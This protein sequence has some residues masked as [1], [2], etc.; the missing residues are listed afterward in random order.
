MKALPLDSRSR[1]GRVPSGGRAC[2]VT[3][4]LHVIARLL[5]SVTLALRGRK[6]EPARAAD[7]RLPPSGGGGSSSAGGL[8]S[9]DKLISVAATAA[10]HGRPDRVHAAKPGQIR[11]GAS[12]GARPRQP[13]TER[14][15]KGLVP[16]TCRLLHRRVGAGDDLPARLRAASGWAA[17]ASLACSS[18]ESSARKGR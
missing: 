6:R 17:A 4:P 3:L 9:E 18:D 15:P 14:R 5:G 16:R 10:A 1:L 8:R 2:P 7:N 13:R 12:R 11:C